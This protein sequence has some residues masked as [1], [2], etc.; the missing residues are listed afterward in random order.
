M[1]V[2]AKGAKR[3]LV[4]ASFLSVWL[5]KLIFSLIAAIERRNPI[6]PGVARGFP[7][8]YMS[9]F[10]F[11]VVIPAVFVIVNFLM[12]VF[13]SRIPKWLAIIASTLQCALLLILLFLASGGV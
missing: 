4:F 8:L 12:F 10:G 5:L 6:P 13:A 3:R 2:P 1:S 9:D 11:Y 7:S